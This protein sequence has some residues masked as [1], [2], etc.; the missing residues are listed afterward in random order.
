MV[1]MS[2]CVSVYLGVRLK[3]GIRKLTRQ[4]N[5]VDAGRISDGGFLFLGSASPSC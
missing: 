4:G 2:M 3:M 5:D 1:S